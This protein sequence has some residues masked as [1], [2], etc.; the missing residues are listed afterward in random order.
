MPEGSA[1]GWDTEEKRGVDVADDASAGAS[2]ISCTLPLPSPL[3][4][5]LVSI[6]LSD[7]FVGTMSRKDRKER[8]RGNTW[9]RDARVDGS[10]LKRQ[11]ARRRCASDG[12]IAPG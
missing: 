4:F 12:G 8:T 6:H 11:F 5:F 10:G 7:C 9:Q 3:P 2:F 1:R